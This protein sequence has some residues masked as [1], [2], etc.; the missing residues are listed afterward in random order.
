M[1]ISYT[2]DFPPLYIPLSTDCS[3]R[4]NNRIWEWSLNFVFGPS[5]LAKK[6]SQ[7]AFIKWIY[8]FFLSLPFS[9][10]EAGQPPKIS[11]HPGD[12]VVP[13]NEPVTLNCK[14]EGVP[15]PPI[16]WTKDGKSLVQLS[17][18]RKLRFPLPSGSLFF[19]R[20]RTRLYK[21]GNT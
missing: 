19:L 17:D 7:D 14:A 3:S 1:L 6:K 15:T 12:Y 5:T 13:R 9:V 8:L 11:E 18:S 20:V 4:G 21:H 2:F 16:S 10:C